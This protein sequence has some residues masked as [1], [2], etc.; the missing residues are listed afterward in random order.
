MPF[1]FPSFRPAM[2]GSAK[3][4]LC[5]SYVVPRVQV[6]LIPMYASRGFCSIIIWAGDGNLAFSRRLLNP[7]CKFHGNRSQAMQM[8][9]DGCVCRARWENDLSGGWQPKR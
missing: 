7:C 5:L 4:E 3:T 1:L 6:I 9:G 2:T 8:D